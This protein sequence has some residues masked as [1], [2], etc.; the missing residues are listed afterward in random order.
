MSGT[1]TLSID[2]LA[3]LVAR[4]LPTGLFL[5]VPGDGPNGT[6]NVMTIGWGAIG[7]FWRRDVFIAPVRPQRHTYG[8]LEKAGRFTVSIPEPGTMGKALAQA[9]TLS[10]RDGDKFQAIGLKTR[11]AQTMAVPIVDGCSMYVE[12]VVRGK[13]TFATP[14][15]D[16]EVVQSAY[17]AE[18][19]HVLYYG[20][21]IA[22]YTGDAL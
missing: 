13:N 9:G 22:R 15:M 16:P 7:Y 4:Q 18:D 10:G 17:P 20:E 12:C 5:C 1:M 19:Y 6:P 21:I 14:Q 3:A 11:M 8:L 2:A